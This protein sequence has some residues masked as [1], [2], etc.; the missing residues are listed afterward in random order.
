MNAQQIPPKADEPE[1]RTLA[2]V[3]DRFRVDTR[4]V[5]RLIDSGELP[6]VRVGDRSFRVPSVA[7]DAFAGQKAA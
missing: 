2:E 3:A 1:F 6:A 4:T 5:R 7:V